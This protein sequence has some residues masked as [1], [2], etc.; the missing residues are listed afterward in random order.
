MPPRLH[1]TV[2]PQLSAT[3]EI[4]A[5]PMPDRE[6]LS[7]FTETRDEAF[8]AR[9]LATVRPWLTRFFEPEVRGLS[10]VPDGAALLVA[11]HNAGVLMPD[12]WILGD[13]LFGHMGARGLPYALAHDVLFDVKGL[14]QALE[15]LGGVRA[16]PASAHALF[17]S[18]HKAL[19]YPGGDREVMRPYRDRHRIVFGPRRG[20]VKMAIREGVPVVPVVTAGAHEAFM[21]LDDGGLVA[22]WL[23]LPKWA[24][25]NVLPTVLSFPWGL[26][27]GFPP[28][29]VPVPTRIVMD[30]LP[31]IHFERSGEEAAVDDAYVERCHDRVVR[32]MQARLDEIVSTEEIGVRARLKRRWP[33]AEPIGR[34]LE[35]LAD[36]IMARSPFVH[37][38]LGST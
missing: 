19:V 38:P 11:N 20:Y 26:T 13:A 28:P 35:E 27:F 36:G 14:R 31:P 10:N 6:A 9:F 30:V 24:R 34:F 15:K 2:D 7:T 25:I 8:V 12:V 18:G 32:A 21:V 37:S 33:K 16:S 5:R 4:D 29:Y 22:R 23:G 3:R 1:D 17:A